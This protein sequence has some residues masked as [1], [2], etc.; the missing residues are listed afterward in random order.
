LATTFARNH[1]V[2]DFRSFNPSGF[3]CLLG[4]QTASRRALYPIDVEIYDAELVHGGHIAATVVL[5]Q[6]AG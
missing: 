4:L 6:F 5:P 1:W 2:R 3:R